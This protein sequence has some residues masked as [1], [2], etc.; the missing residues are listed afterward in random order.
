M[1]ANRSPPSSLVAC[2]SPADPLPSRRSDRLP[3]PLV[4][5][6]WQLY[7]AFIREHTRSLVDPTNVQLRPLCLELMLIILHVAR[8]TTT[9]TR[10]D[11]ARWLKPFFVPESLKHAWP[12]DQRADLLGHLIT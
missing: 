4:A 5:R 1:V 3:S 6:A 9:A 11:A 12:L 2:R 7:I 10:Y 8:A